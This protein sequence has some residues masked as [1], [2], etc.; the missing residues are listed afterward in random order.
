MHCTLWPLITL[1]FPDRRI[2]EE[3]P[4][5][6]SMSWQVGGSGRFQG[7]ETSRG[8]WRSVEFNFSPMSA[9]SE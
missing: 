7:M 8:Y 3:Y 1:P 9:H 5:H 4:G 6:A 2:K